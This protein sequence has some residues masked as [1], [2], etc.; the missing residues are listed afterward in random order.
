[1]TIDEKLNSDN[2]NRSNKPLGWFKRT[3]LTAVGVLAIGV[4]SAHSGPIV[5]IDENDGA[6]IYLSPTQLRWDYGVKNNSHIEP[7]LSPDGAKIDEVN[8]YGLYSHIMPTFVGFPDNWN[9]GAVETSL[10][11]KLWNISLTTFNELAKIRP[12]STK[13]FGIITYIPEDALPLII[14]ERF[15]QSKFGEA[16]GWFPD[17]PGYSFTGPVGIEQLTN[18]V[19]EPGTGA[20]L[21]PVVLT[22]ALTRKK[23]E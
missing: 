17:L 1:M 4:A 16:Y 22:Y 20:L 6:P 10:D 5:T 18:P 12:G 11:S 7:P 21:I 8:L 3:V 2:S 9:G 19:S 13:D 23:R 14:G 15:G